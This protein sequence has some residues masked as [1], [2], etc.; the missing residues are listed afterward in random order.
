MLDEVIH[1][2]NGPLPVIEDGIPIP[3]TLRDGSYGKNRK[4]P[5]RDLDVGQSFF[6]PSSQFPPS[7]PDGVRISCLGQ[8]RRHGFEITTRKVEGGARVWRTA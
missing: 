2:N 4:Y 5:V 8:A 1:M 6:V 3:G 7:G